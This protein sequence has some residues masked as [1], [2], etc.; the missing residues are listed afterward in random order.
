MKTGY[1][2]VMK[3]LYIYIYILDTELYITWKNWNFISKHDGCMDGWC[4]LKP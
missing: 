3:T 1:D 4:H 2:R